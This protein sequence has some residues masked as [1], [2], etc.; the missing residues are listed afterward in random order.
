MA[1]AALNNFVEFMTKITAAWKLMP[2]EIKIHREKKKSLFQTS[3]H[4]FKKLSGLKFKFSKNDA[5][6][7]ACYV[8]KR[9]WGLKIIWKQ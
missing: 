2:E 9:K 4:F 6:F 3:E 1:R 8:S 7:E 5:C